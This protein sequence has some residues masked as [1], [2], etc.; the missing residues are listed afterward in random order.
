[1]SLILDA[2]KKSEAERQR[3]QPPTLHAHFH[4]PRRVRRTPWVAGAGAVLLAAGLAGSGLWLTRGRTGDDAESAGSPIARAGTATLQEAADPTATTQPVAPGAT[5]EPVATVAAATTAPDV[6]N[7]EPVA[8]TVFG[9]VAGAGA[10]GTVSGGGLPVP[11]RA[12][13]YTPSAT[14][15]PESAA[16]DPVPAAAPPPPPAP[17]APVVVAAPVPAE[18]PAPVQ[19]PPIQ[20]PPAVVDHGPSGPTTTE[21][22]PSKPEEVLPVIFQLPYATRKDLPKLELSMHV[23]SPEPAE[24][25]IVLNGKRYTLETPAPGPE[26]TLLDIVADGAVFEFRGQ[27]FLLPR[28]TY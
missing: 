7:V 4:T 8:N 13:L 11:Q 10:G 28:Q 5:A 25:F 2:L 24:R 27:R 22:T 1:M 14:P 17:E 23:F 15:L 9:G 6:A 12:M 16:S 19:P 20:P 21:A 26:L 3:G 18:Q